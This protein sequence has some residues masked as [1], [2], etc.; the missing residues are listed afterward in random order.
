MSRDLTSPHCRSGTM[1]SRCREATGAA[2]HH[3]LVVADGRARCRLKSS[4]R[5]VGAGSR[6]SRC[7]L[8]LAGEAEVH[9]GET[10]ELALA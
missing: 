3:E 5:Q 1:R 9:P 8:E 2:L 10:V 6:L 7:E 4:R